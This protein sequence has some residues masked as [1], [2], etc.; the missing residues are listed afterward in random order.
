VE[1]SLHVF[2]GAGVGVG[3]VGEPTFKARL[4]DNAGP[5]DF[6]GRLA[7][8]LFAFGS[9]AFVLLQGWNREKLAG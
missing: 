3:Q 8:G 4:G 1:F 5:F 6:K 9:F 7:F 2:C